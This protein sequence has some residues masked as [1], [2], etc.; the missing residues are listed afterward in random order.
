MTYLVVIRGQH[1][2]HAFDLTLQTVDSLYIDVGGSCVVA[3]VAQR[4]QVHLTRV[5]GS[6][7]GILARTPT[8]AHSV[9]IEGAGCSRIYTLALGAV[10]WRAFVVDGGSSLLEMTLDA[11]SKLGPATDDCCLTVQFVMAR[12][13]DVARYQQYNNTTRAQAHAYRSQP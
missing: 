6:A 4:T 11:A 12:C 2:A 9:L 10:H 1:I 5:A 13:Q 8:P 7:R 3:N